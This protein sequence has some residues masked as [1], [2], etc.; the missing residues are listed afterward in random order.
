MA[1]K[2]KDMKRQDLSLKNDDISDGVRNY[3]A[4]QEL[5]D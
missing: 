5:N 1:K 4:Y 3:S 2:A